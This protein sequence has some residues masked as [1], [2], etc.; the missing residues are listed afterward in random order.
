MDGFVVL[1]LKGLDTPTLIR[2][3]HMD[4]TSGVVR[5]G[6]W[7]DTRGR[8]DL[9]TAEINPPFAAFHVVFVLH[10]YHVRHVN[11]SRLGWLGG[12]QLFGG[13]CEILS[14]EEAEIG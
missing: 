4:E 10:V 7:I 14:I 6:G 5:H 9:D 2:V 1:A 11:V 8:G 3:D 13:L 12:L